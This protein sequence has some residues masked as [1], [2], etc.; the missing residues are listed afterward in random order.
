MNRAH[1]HRPSRSRAALV[2]CD[3][4]VRSFVGPIR[5]PGDRGYNPVAHGNIR[6]VE[7]CGCGMAVRI[8]NENAG[9]REVGPWIQS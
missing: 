7:A 8:V 5:F 2:E 6:Y 9:Q 4:S 1:Q 3:A